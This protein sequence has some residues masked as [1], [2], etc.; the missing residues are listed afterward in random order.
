MRTAKLVRHTEFTT[1]DRKELR[2]KLDEI[3]RTGVSVS[4]NEMF[5]GSAGVS[6]PIYGIDGNVIAAIAIGAPTDRFAGEADKLR[7]IVLDV[8]KRASGAQVS[9]TFRSG[10]SDD[11]QSASNRAAKVGGLALS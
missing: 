11:S 6:A 4:V 10:A 1:I 7:D 3:R 2:R 9:D 5:I 8:S